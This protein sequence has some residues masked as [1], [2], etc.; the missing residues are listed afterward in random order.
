MRL[1]LD[2][3]VTDA[4][5]FL[6]E[7]VGDVGSALSLTMSSLRNKLH[8]LDVALEKKTCEPSFHVDEKEQVEDIL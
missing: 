7:R 3:E 8:L 6:L 2:H 5:V 4:A 1:C